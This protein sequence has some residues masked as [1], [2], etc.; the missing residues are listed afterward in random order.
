MAQQQHQQII[1]A[2]QLVLKF[3]SIGRCNNY[4]ILWNIT[5]SVECKIVGQILIDHALSYA[6][7]TTADVLAVYLQQKEIIYTVDMFHSTFKFPVETLNNPFIAPTTIEYIQP[8]MKIVGYQGEVDKVS[9]FFTK[10][11][12]QLWQTMFKYP[13]FTNFIIA[14]L[15]KK[16]PSIPQRLEEDNH[17]IKDDIPLEY[18]EYVKVFVGVD[19]LT[20]HPQPVESTQGTI[21]T[22]SAHKTPTPTAISSD[23]FQNKRKRKQIAGETSLP[24]P[25]LKI[26]VKQFKSS[27]TPIPPPSDDRERDEE[28]YASE[29][30]DS[31]FH[32]D[33]DSGNRIEPGSHKEN[34]ET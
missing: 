17:S 19:V 23:V 32:D 20:I 27:D 1:L 9:A 14:D 7:T 25:S 33:D 28:S 34:S 18:K 15:M 8:F 21:R 29:F 11:L 22:S 5:C 26:R 30:V 16:F 31:V 12:A 24:K 2:D 13:R 6:L 3:Q 10:C 4:V